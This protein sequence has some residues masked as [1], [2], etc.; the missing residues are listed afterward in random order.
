ML[1]FVELLL[2]RVEE[3]ELASRLA[4][5]IERRPEQAREAV[6]LLGG[7]PGV[8]LLSLAHLFARDDQ[9]ADLVIGFQDR[10]GPPAERACIWQATPRVEVGELE[11]SLDM[12]Q[13]LGAEIAWSGRISLDDAF[14]AVLL[15]PGLLLVASPTL[16]PDEEVAA[17]RRV[18]WERMRHLGSLAKRERAAQRALDALL[19]LPA[20][21]QPLPQGGH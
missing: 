15:G 19:E 8:E 6:F 21:Q 12:K 11:V 20:P 9:P 5:A 17:F 10:E 7:A 4:E 3:A 16:V 2:F 13:S 1:V 14:T 18:W